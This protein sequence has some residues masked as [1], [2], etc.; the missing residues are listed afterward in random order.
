MNKDLRDEIFDLENR[1]QQP[2]VRKSLEDLDELLSDDFLEFGSS[3]ESYTK[4]DVLVNLPA[5][6]EIKFTMSEFKINILAEDTVQTLFRTEKINSET[7]AVSR[8]LRSSI[9]KNENGKWKM[10]FHQ[11]TPQSPK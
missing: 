5:S 8:S 11:G 3:G 1:L 7:G 6:P 9:W 2:E 4:K 10:I